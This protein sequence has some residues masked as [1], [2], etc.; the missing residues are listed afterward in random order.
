MNELRKLFPIT[1]EL[2]YLN[3][4]ASSPLSSPVKGAIE[5]CL[6][7]QLSD[8]G[9]KYHDKRDERQA[10]VRRKVAKLIG[11]SPDE[12]AILRNTG[13]G[14]S[15]VASGLDWQEGDNVVTNDL[16]HPTNMYPWMNLEDR[17]GVEV[18]IVPATEGRVP[19]A[20]LFATA[21]DRTRV[22]A[23]SFVEFSN[24]FRHDLPTIGNFCRQKGIYLVVD[25]VQALGVLDFDVKRSKVDFLSAAAFKWLLGPMGISCFYCRQELLDRLWLTHP[26]PRGMVPSDTGRLLDYRFTPRPTAERFE[27]GSKNYLGIYGFDAGLDIIEGAGLENIEKHAL[28]LTGLLVN[29]LQDK[30]YRILSS[31]DPQERSGIISFSHPRHDAAQLVQRLL[32]ARIVVAWREGAIRVSIHLYNNEEDVDRLIQALP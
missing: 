19:S 11:A 14:L 3:T 27:G 12:I 20:D 13:E 32:D 7:D 29:R 21:D 5:T 16:E 30:G 8:S 25:A 2:V 4:A 17:F 9:L 28:G 6:H 1:Q 22:I 10:A 23:L 31:L 18:R 26:G 24:G 15:V